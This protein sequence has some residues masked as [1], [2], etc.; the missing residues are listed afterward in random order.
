[1]MREVEASIV[2]ALVIKEGLGLRSFSSNSETKS[3]ND[4]EDT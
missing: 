2:F 3:A 1:M 4:I